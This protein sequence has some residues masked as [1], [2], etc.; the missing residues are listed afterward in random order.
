MPSIDHHLSDSGMM[1]M[2]D[3]DQINGRTRSR[4]FFSGELAAAG[5]SASAVVYGNVEGTAGRVWIERDVDCDALSIIDRP[6]DS[7]NTVSLCCFLTEAAT[8]CGTASSGIQPLGLSDRGYTVWA[9]KAT[10][11]SRIMTNAPYIK[12]NV[13]RGDIMISVGAHYQAQ[14]IAGEQISLPMW[15]QINE[16]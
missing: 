8:A 3:N 11:S 7:I 6:A 2:G 15:I 10:A 14:V 16:G 5:D 4:V 1:W 9:Y 12:C 13:S